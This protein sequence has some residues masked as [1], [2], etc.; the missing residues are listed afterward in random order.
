M[1]RK[2]D[3]LLLCIHHLVVDGVS[4]R[5]LLEDIMD[6]YRKGKAGE[7]I[8]LPAKTTSFQEWSRKQESY[9]RS[10]R[11]EEEESYWREIEEKICRGKLEKAETG[12]T[13]IGTVKVE[14]NPEV[15]EN[16]C[17]RPEE[18]TIRK[19]MICS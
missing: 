11:L 6:G 13:G 18:H 5:I 10:V 17:I 8:H 15:T 1:E 19:S 12:E 9:A 2:K 4:W 7:E 3:W 14:L 16:C